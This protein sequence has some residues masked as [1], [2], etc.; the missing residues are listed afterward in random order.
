MSPCPSADPD[1]PP[2]PSACRVRQLYLEALVAQRIR[3][4]ILLQIMG[5]LPS[6][7]PLSGRASFHDSGH[8]Y[9]PGLTVARTVTFISSGLALSF[10]FLRDSALCGLWVV[11]WPLHSEKHA[12]MSSPARQPASLINEGGEV[13]DLGALRRLSLSSRR[14]SHDSALSGSGGGGEMIFFFFFA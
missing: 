10:P 14:C 8:G 5:D 13:D 9:L 4:C 7:A 11:F 1:S 3:F 6:P 2:S 12:Q